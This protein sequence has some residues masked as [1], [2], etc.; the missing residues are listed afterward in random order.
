[1]NDNTKSKKHSGVGKQ[2]SIHAKKNSKSGAAKHNTETVFDEIGYS[3]MPQ[4]TISA[5]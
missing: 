3:V 5:L 1:M 4:T 2:A